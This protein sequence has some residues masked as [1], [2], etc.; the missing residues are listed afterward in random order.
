[1]GDSSR[2]SPPTRNSGRAWLL[3]FHRP[4]AGDRQRERSVGWD[5]KTVAAH[6]AGR[7]GA[8][9]RAPVLS[10]GHDPDML[11]QLDPVSRRLGI[12]R[13]QEAVRRGTTGLVKVLGLGDVRFGEAGIADAR[14]EPICCR[15][16]L[17]SYLP[18]DLDGAGGR[19]DVEPDDRG[20]LAAHGRFDP[21]GR[22]SPWLRQLIQFGDSAGGVLGNEDINCRVRRQGT[23]RAAPKR[24]R[25]GRPPG[26]RCAR[27]PA[28]SAS[29]AGTMSTAAPA[30]HE[31]DNGTG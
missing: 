10:V 17:R 1:M 22:P 3:R 6:G 20:P 9:A 28:D 24:L 30:H 2:A 5:R 7:D 14:A 19:L 13:Q 18:M 31:V 29:A 27:Q 26:M 21:T 8:V 15:A 4:R 25:A 16:V 12:D 23:P 11:I